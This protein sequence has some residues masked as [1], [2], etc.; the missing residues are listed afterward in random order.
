MDEVLTRRRHEQVEVDVQVS[1]TDAARLAQARRSLTLA[2]DA[3]SGQ[4]PP[5]H[6]TNGC[7]CRQPGNFICF[8]IAVDRFLKRRPC[9]VG[10]E[11][12][13]GTLLLRL[14]KRTGAS[15]T[16][17]FLLLSHDLI[18]GRVTHDVL[19]YPKPNAKG[20]DGY[21]MELDSRS[22]DAPPLLQTLKRFVLRSKV[23]I[24]DVSDEYDVW[25]VWGSEELNDR[26][27][28]T[29]REWSHSRSGIIEP[30]WDQAREWPWK[31]AGDER[32]SLFDRRAKGMGSRVLVPKGDIRMSFRD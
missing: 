29:K 19:L 32:P 3:R 7:S 6:N 14:L 31:I 17:L 8:R 16:T 2:Y 27:E 1:T 26:E 22:S 20:Q 5:S 12:A 28:E 9:I 18:Q 23:R 4:A 10:P 21:L 30:V 15:Q 11:S 25:S 24:R 13:S